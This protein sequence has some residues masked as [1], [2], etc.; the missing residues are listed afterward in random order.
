MKALKIVLQM[1]N[2]GGSQV[3]L[4]APWVPFTIKIAPDGWR[5]RIALEWLAISPHY[6]YRTPAN[7]DL[8]HL[9]FLRSESKR[10]AR[11][12]HL[13]VEHIVR[14]HLNPDFTVLDYG[15][16]PGFLA[17]TASTHARR[18]IACDISK[19]VLECAKALNGRPNLEYLA[20]PPT[21]R[22]DIED[23][24][25]DL[26]YSFA[27]FQHIED[28]VFKKILDELGRVMKN[29]AQALCHVVLVGASGWRTEVDWREDHSLAGRAKWIA[30]GH[31]F[32]RDPV[33]VRVIVETAG[34]CE[35]AIESIR[36]PTLDDDIAHQHLL[37]FK[38]HR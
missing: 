1:A 7:K 29:G 28:A 20:V 25:V 18:V 24:S 37:R 5:E 23:Q 15:C 14:P 6:F 30:G 36:V 17:A 19:G 4:G 33:G 9:E 21:G 35:I 31:S 34:F 12:R 10:N 3:F 8:G 22:L 32:A 27:V 16:G 38:K 11:S 2:S 13:L 26:V